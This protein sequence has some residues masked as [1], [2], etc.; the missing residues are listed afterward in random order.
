MGCS[1]YV[2]RLTQFLML[3]M[4]ALVLIL[5][6]CPAFSLPSAS[7][8]AT[9]DW[10]TFQVTTDPGMH[11]TYTS[12]YSNLIDDAM[13]LSH[14]T[15][16]AHNQVYKPGWLVVSLPVATVSYDKGTASGSASMSSTIFTTSASVA[17]GDWPYKDSFWGKGNFR[18]LLF[19]QCLRQWKCNHERGLLDFRQL[20]K[21]GRR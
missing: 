20:H 9:I 18:W 11:L 16:D 19:F 2:S 4:A 17:S 15:L 13:D 1:D 21:Y 7:G 8:T 14:N 3:A 5:S 6:P 12:E 10:N